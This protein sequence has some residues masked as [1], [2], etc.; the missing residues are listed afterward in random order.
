MNPNDTKPVRPDTNTQPIP[1]KS[2]AH[3][4]GTGVGAAGGAVAGAV[5]GSTVAGPVGTVVGAAAGAATGALAGQNT[6]KVV[7][8]S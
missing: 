8:P 3:P 7:N 5:I 2:D 6:A 1:V 4:V